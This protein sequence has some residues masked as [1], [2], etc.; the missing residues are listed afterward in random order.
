MK[1]QEVVK[2]LTEEEELFELVKITKPTP[3]EKQLLDKIYNLLSGS[4]ALDSIDPVPFGDMG[5]RV[6]F[7]GTDYTVYVKGK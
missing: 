3:S 6:K 7:K 4:S 5:L 2:Y 1:D